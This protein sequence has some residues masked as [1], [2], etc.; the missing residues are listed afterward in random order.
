MMVIIQV[1]SIQF[2]CLS[3]YNIVSLFYHFSQS[4]LIRMAEVRPDPTT[5]DCF[6]S[7]KPM[8]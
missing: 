3:K 5:D 8:H 6:E 2:K 1:N 7:L 4:S